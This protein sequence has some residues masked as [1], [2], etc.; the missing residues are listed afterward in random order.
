MPKYEVLQTFWW[1]GH[2]YRK[3]SIVNISN[4]GLVKNLT[5]K[6]LIAPPASKF[7]IREFEKEN[8]EDSQNVI[9]LED[10][11]FLDRL[12][13]RMPDEITYNTKVESPEYSPGV[14]P[15]LLP[16][17][18]AKKTGRPRSRMPRFA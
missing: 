17:P 8:N 13:G 5:R 14:Q 1:E 2:N 9:D 7:K 15:E 10:P 16:E 3:G 18:V 4:D 11:L 6:K 12:E